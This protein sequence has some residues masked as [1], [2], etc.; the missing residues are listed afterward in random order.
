[1][2]VSLGKV[3]VGMHVASNRIN[4]HGGRTTGKAVSAR[5]MYCRSFV[6]EQT[7]SLS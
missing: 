1:M 4:T 7:V 2:N 5:V 3:Y 6:I